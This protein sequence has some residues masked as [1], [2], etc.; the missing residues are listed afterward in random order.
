MSLPRPQFDAELLAK[1]NELGPEVF[2][3]VTAET[4]SAAREAI[5]STLGGITDEDIRRKGAIEFEE[6]RVAGPPGAPDISLL[7]CKPAGVQGSLPC[8]YYIHGGGM[9]I[10]G[11]RLGISYLLN[12]VEEYQLVGVSVEY[13]V[14]PEHPHPAPVEDCYAGLVWTAAHAEELGF[15]P[16][17]ML[18][19]GPSAGGGLAAAVALM[20]RDRGG[21]PL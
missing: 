5:V 14:A 2:P 15:D 17:R 6:R 18:I 20:A 16:N 1:L 7:I 8:I 9:I 11:N 4:I 10:G 13:R 21:P 19:A 3:I 12:W